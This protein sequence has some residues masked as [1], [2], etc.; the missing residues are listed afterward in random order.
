MHAGIGGMV[1]SYV[2]QYSTLEYQK[3][4]WAVSNLYLYH[5]Y[6]VRENNTSETKTP[7]YSPK[8]ESF[9]LTPTLSHPPLSTAEHAPVC[10]LC[11]AVLSG[12]WELEQSSHIWGRSFTR[13]GCCWC[14]VLHNYDNTTQ[15]HATAALTMAQQP[16][17]DESVLAAF[18]A[19]PCQSPHI[20]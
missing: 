8:Y 20:Q 5:T 11:S 14:I 18:S 13:L 15:K 19:N 2:G 1:S 7:T 4:F 17:H 3:L 12:G 6:H 16:C 10:G 9:A